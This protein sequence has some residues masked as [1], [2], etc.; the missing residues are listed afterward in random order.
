MSSASPALPFTVLSEKGEGDGRKRRPRQRVP[1]PRYR[2]PTEDGCDPERKHQEYDAGQITNAAHLSDAQIRGGKIG[3]STGGKA[4][5]RDV[6][7]TGIFVEDQEA[8]LDFYT[9]KLGLELVQDEP[10]GA[11]WITIS[12]V[13]EA[14][15]V[16][17]KIE[18]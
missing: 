6:P 5:I 14:R 10:Y 4:M 18:L 16:L 13:I 17:K 7:Q 15:I 8:A 2:E 1:K 3:E 9:N 12:P 11:R